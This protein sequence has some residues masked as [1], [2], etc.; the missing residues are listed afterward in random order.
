[1]T[2]VRLSALENALQV[3][4]SLGARV[5]DVRMPDLAGL[6]DTFSLSLAAKTA[7]QFRYTPVEPFSRLATDGCGS[8]RTSTS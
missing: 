8:D 3:L 4:A 2:A 1:L 6:V 5:V 7:V